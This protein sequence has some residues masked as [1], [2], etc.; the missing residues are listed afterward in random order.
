MQRRS[1]AGSAAAALC[2]LFLGAGVAHADDHTTRYLAASVAMQ[3]SAQLPDNAAPAAREKAN[4]K[5]LRAHGFSRKSFAQ[6]G[7]SLAAKPAV[8]S[9]IKRGIGQC[10]NKKKLLGR[11]TGTFKQGQIDGRIDLNFQ[12]SSLR[13]SMTVTYKGRRISI[14]L[15]NQ[16]LKAGRVL[17]GGTANRA[18]Y[19]LVLTVLPGGNE[20]E[21]LLVIDGGSGPDRASF[22]IPRK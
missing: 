16:N 18:S 11:F 12:R 21:G 19:A 5:I 7:F 10:G 14:P 15:R 8:Q 3:C 17:A 22:K 6:A 4:D 9:E 2:V 13:G 1:F 20:I